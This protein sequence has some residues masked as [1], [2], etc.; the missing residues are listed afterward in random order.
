MKNLILIAGVAVMSFTNPISATTTGDT[1]IKYPHGT[2]EVMTPKS[3]TDVQAKTIEEVIAED[4]QI[5]ESAD[6]GESADSNMDV[7]AYTIAEDNRIIES[8]FVDVVYPLD[9]EKINR[10]L[11]VKV[12][13]KQ[14]ML[15]EL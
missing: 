8:D 14:R 9:F 7:M 10:K 4:N 2:E 15:G 5:T 6:A 11:F 3:I 12:N 1:V 13:D